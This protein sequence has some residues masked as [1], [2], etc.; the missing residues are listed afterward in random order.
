M[1]WIMSARIFG[2]LVA[3]ALGLAAGLGGAGCDLTACA[4]ELMGY[5]E[6]RCA[7]GDDY[8]CHSLAVCDA[9]ACDALPGC[10]AD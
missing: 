1:L 3:A 5:H 2:A 10:G 9:A 4:P 8:G 7:A 6:A